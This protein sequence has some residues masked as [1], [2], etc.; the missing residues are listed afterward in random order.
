[1]KDFDKTTVRLT[2][3][4]CF[5]GRTWVAGGR[6]GQ[7][8]AFPGVEGVG[9]EVTGGGGGEVVRVTNLN[10]DGPGSLRDAVSKPNRLVVCDVSGLIHI[11]SALV[12]SDNLT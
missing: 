11:R 10:D 9:A 4:A 7:T 12:F 6:V 1:M 5:L 3:C 8:L 2:A